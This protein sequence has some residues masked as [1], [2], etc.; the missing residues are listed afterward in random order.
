MKSRHSRF[1]NSSEKSNLDESEIKINWNNIAQDRWNREVK[2]MLLYNKSLNRDFKDVVKE[3]KEEFM[4]KG[5]KI[6]GKIAIKEKDIKRQRNSDTFL[7]GEE[8]INMFFD[9]FK[10]NLMQKTE[11]SNL[12]LTKFQRIPYNCLNWNDDKL[13]VTIQ[14]RLCYDQNAFKTDLKVEYL[15]KYDKEYVYKIEKSKDR[16]T[17]IN[18]LLDGIEISKKEMFRK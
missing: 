1:D 18:E 10:Q 7:D 8:E 15:P 9:E 2:Q 17:I 5:Y 12:Y 13:D 3:V 11:K 6:E 4:E 14:N 16:K